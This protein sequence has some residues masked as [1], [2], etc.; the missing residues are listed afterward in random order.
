MKTLGVDASAGGDRCMWLKNNM[1]ITALRVE[2]FFGSLKHD[3]LLRILQPTRGFTK[4]DV[5]TYMK[6][7]RI[8]RLLTVNDY[9]AIHCV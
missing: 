2:R 9:S 3:W 6:Y 5:G 4:Q 1:N 7:Y 8:E